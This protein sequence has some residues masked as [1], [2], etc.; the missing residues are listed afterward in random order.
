MKTIFNKLAFLI[1][2]GLTSISLVS[3]QQLTQTIRGTIYDVDS[4]TPLIG[5]N[6]Y[7]PDA[8]P[9][10]GA[11]TDVNGKF[12]LEK[13]P[14]G[15]VNL[16]I[17]CLGYE[18]KNIPNLLIASAK[19]TVLEVELS[20][21]LIKLE[22][23]V[24]KA[25]KNK[26]EVINGMA[27][28]SSKTFSVEETNRYAG[29][30]NDPA[31]MVSAY[32]GVTGNPE[33]TNDIVVRGN[34]PK[35]ILWRLEGV[36]IPNPNHFAENGGTG[37]PVNTLNSSMLS[38]SD[39]FSG[40]FAPEY[41]N[42]LSG[43][44]D[45]KFRSGNN[46]KREYTFSAGVLGTDIT[47]EGPFKEGYAGS[48]LANY[49]YSSLDL[50][51][52]LGL[53]DFGGVPKY[54]DASFKVVLPTKKLGRF[55]IFGLGGI[56]NITSN[57]E[58]DDENVYGTAYV[59]ANLG[60]TGLNHVYTLDSNTYIRSSLS[61][62][63]SMSKETWDM[64]DDNNTMFTAGVDEFTESTMRLSTVVNRK[65]DSR[66][67]V[68]TGA[69][70]SRLNYD[71]T[72]LHDF[73]NS[74]S[75]ITG[76]DA[77]GSTNLLQA[78][79]SWK[80]RM[81]K[82]VT[83][84]AGLHFTH[85]LLNNNISLEPRL[86]VKWKLTPK[87]NITLGVGKHSKV[88]NISTYLASTDE[89]NPQYKPNKNLELTKAWHFVLGYGFLVSENLHF[90]TEVY[91]QHLFDVPV[92]N[93]PNSTYSILNATSYYSTRELINEGTG[94]NYGVELSLERFF[95]N[96]FY[97]LATTS[98]YKSRYTPMDG[99]ERNTA[100]DAN[101]AANLLLG[102]EF[103]V[104]NGKKNKTIGINA[105]ASF[106]G[107]NRYTPIDLAASNEAGYTIYHEDQM[108][109]EKG[110]DVF[111]INLGLTYRV[112]RKNTTH[113]FKIDVQNITNNQAVVSEYYSQAQRK[114]IKSNQLP[115]IPNI[116]YTLKF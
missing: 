51:T 75:F 77:K 30:L 82:D 101:Y 23:A 94:R 93:E 55:T 16:K 15:R 116:I 49:R 70:F 18:D 92:E 43:V 36:D 4:K 42:A 115:M 48:Y 37:G 50:L 58:D 114:L 60:V 8:D 12:R 108:Y 44:F 34:S 100:F 74:G 90:K 29:S 11:I 109:S 85:L 106:L 98:L 80:Y 99:I 7:I 26:S 88:E 61:V 96:N 27:T 33:G 107:A 40:A 31:R 83:V 24:I 73:K 111:F 66:L 97:Y 79:T 64:L 9:I 21:S 76:I 68:Q 103:K 1:I 71:M 104:G 112:D 102:K 22:A 35:G 113:E 53:L 56:S 95:S 72:E 105:K 46:E 20:E 3:A 57:D 39:F 69:T 87:Q 78:F 41:G 84:I 28:V 81:H 13:V 45:V 32:A 19:E 47:V 67:R 10:I 91:Y 54:Q 25:R 5:A 62:S 38:N 14:V 59:D 2:L 86:G 17:S 110:D 52:S 65:I 6:V 63:S 89:E